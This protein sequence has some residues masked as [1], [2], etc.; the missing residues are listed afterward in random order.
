[1]LS[2]MYVYLLIKEQ[3]YV[4]MFV[5]IQRGTDINKYISH[6]ISN[7]IKWGLYWN[8][9]TSV[10]KYQL[11]GDEEMDEP[12]LRIIQSQELSSTRDKEQVSL[13]SKQYILTPF[14]DE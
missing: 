13:L 9:T 1:M 5:S 2:Y 4:F 3:V 7:I 14:G 8:R 6:Y 12:G 10:D 11:G